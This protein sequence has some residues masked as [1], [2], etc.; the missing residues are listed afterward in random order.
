MTIYL[1]RSPKGIHK[2][3]P[4]F[5]DTISGQPFEKC[6]ICEIVIWGSG[7]PYVVEKYV[8]RN[9][10]TQKFEPIFE[11][12]MCHKCVNDLM[13]SYSTGSKDDIMSLFELYDKLNRNTPMF[14]EPADHKERVEQSLSKC[15]LLRKQVSQLKTCQVLASFVDDTFDAD[16]DPVVLSEEALLMV[17]ERLSAAT[18]DEIDNFF[19]SYLSGPPE[20]REFFKSPTRRYIML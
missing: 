8:Q 3:T 11:Y 7:V 15:Y 20:W 18:L 16:Y 4:F 17:H 14:I 6:L 12:S 9:R 1:N 19:G 10:F 2:I 13:D 5:Y